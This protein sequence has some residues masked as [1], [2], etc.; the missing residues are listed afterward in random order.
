MDGSTCVSAYITFHARLVPFNRI[1][2]QSY[3]RVYDVVYRLEITVGP[4]LFAV[5]RPSR[6]SIS[7]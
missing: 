5:P 1:R 4:E 3:V 6:N 2:H 7:K